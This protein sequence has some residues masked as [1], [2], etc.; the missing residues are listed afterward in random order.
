LAQIQQEKKPIQL[1][2]LEEYK[3]WLYATDI[4]PS[5]G[6]TACGNCYGRGPANWLAEEHNTADWKCVP[7]DFY[8]WR[9][10]TPS[11]FWEIATKYYHGLME[12]DENVKET[13][14][15]CAQCGLCNEVCGEVQGPNARLS[16]IFKQFRFIIYEKLGPLK[17]HETTIANIKNCGNS[18]GIDGVPSSRWAD[19]LGVKILKDHDSETLLYVGED[20]AYK[21]PSVAKSTAHVLKAASVDFRIFENE[22]NSGYYLETMGDRWGATELWKKNAELLKKHGIKKLVCL[23]AQDYHVFR[24]EFQS[25][26]DVLHVTEFVSQLITKGKVK[27]RSKGKPRKGVYHD[28]CYLARQAGSTS[29]RERRV[30]DEPRAVLKAIPDFEMLELQKKGR[31]T[32]CAGE[33]GGVKQG[34]P[35]MARW[36][37]EKLIE[38]ASATGTE[39][40]ITATPNEQQHV[41][42]VLASHHLKLECKD[43]MELLAEAV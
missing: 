26:L 10:Y 2:T 22:V 16:D 43:V 1:S 7:F 38:D 27:T 28:P 18:F 36:R 12:I 4:H 35:E 15:S 13:L 19:G 29:P 30:L 41:N 21:L 14:F 39:L 20:A 32:W 25:D 11:A 9:R 8:G 5:S 33:C 23:S 31:W 40:L 37:A 17:A 34:Y 42:E 6:C 3:R 24:R